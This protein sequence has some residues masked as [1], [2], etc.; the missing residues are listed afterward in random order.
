MASLT[1]SSFLVAAAEVHTYIT[2]FILD[3]H[4]AEV[5]IQP[6]LSFNNDHTDFI[7]LKYHYED[8]GFNSIHTLK[9]DQILQT[10]HY[11]GEKK[12]RMW[13]GDS[14]YK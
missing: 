9:A 6:R 14:R 11:V 1:R 3:D 4:T 7:A 10:L 8:V 2:K 13:R 5:K 12:P